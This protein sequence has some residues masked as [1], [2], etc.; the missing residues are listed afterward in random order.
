MPQ[1]SN[2]I[3][4]NTSIQSAYAREIIVPEI[5][6]PKGSLQYVTRE[7]PNMS[8]TYLTFHFKNIYLFFSINKYN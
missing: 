7:W 4:T 5:H 2:T 8:T 6:L 1:I 3:N